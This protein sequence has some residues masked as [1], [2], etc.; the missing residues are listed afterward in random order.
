[1]VNFIL[2]CPDKPGNDEVGA[3]PGNNEEARPNSGDIKTG[4]FRQKGM[5]SAEIV[6]SGGN[7]EAGFLCHPPACPGDPDKTE[8][9]TFP[10][11][12][13]RFLF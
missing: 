2:D 11:M 10:V 7:A 8:G 4:Q 3:R 9:R 13:G 1:M 12:G 6:V 5:A